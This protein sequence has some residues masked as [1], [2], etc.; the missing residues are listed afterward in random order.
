[1]VSA[2]IEQ[3]SSATSSTVPKLGVIA[4]TF[5]DGTVKLFAVPDPDALR[6]SQ[7]AP[8]TGPLFSA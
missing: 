7:K 8:A 6:A 3:L 5:E 4:G 2:C 1:M